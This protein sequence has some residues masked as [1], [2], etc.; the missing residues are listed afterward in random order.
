MWMICATAALVATLSIGLLEPAQALASCVLGGTMLAIAV[1]DL[2]RFVIPDV[3]SLPAI[4]AGLLATGWLT[5]D[6]AS[7]TAILQHTA[8][9]LV[10]AASFYIIGKV[11][12]RVRGRV[13]LGLGDVKLVAV[14]GAWNG[15][16][17]LSL[18]ILIACIGAMVY[19]MA[20]MLGA[21]WKISGTTA[22]PFGAFLAPAIWL[23][24]ILVRAA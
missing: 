16:E 1:S 21:N 10:G 8:A 17:G 18:T 19:V 11:Y 14:A 23:T 3:L 20:R 13:G 5:A 24:W 12:R 6:T 7:H 15:P 9:M 2:R 4:P 22:I